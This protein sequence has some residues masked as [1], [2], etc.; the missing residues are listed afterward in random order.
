MKHPFSAMKQFLIY[1]GSFVLGGLCVLGPMF[2]RASIIHA[3]ETAR[4]EQTMSPGITM[5]MGMLLAPLGG[6][7]AIAIVAIVR[8]VWD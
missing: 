2:V 7:L 1:A 3:E 5:F 6:L 4:H 8:S